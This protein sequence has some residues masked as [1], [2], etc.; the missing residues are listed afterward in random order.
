MQPSTVV[1]Y[2]SNCYDGFGAAFVMWL[3]FGADANYIELHYDGAEPFMPPLGSE[4][5]M[6]DFSYKRE[7]VER[8][9]D[10]LVKSGG[11]LQIIDHHKT[12]IVL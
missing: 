2:H 8:M 4:V 9:H 12:S 11:S 3:K 5:Y 1:L 7:V 6:L 10:H